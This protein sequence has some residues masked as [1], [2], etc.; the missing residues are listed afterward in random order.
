MNEM[1]GHLFSQSNEMAVGHASNKITSVEYMH[2]F[3]F[4]SF[5]LK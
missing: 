1:Q 3:M 4:V 5:T 2:F